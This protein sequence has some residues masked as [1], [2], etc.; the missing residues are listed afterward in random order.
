MLI[1]VA[2]TCVIVLISGVLV[3]KGLPDDMEKSNKYIV[4]YVL[5]SILGSILGLFI[6]SICMIWTYT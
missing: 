1:K 4:G 2:L 5:T 6:T 3:R